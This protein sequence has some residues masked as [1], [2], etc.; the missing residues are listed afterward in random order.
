MSANVECSQIVLNEQ[1][2]TIWNKQSQEEEIQW[3]L[4]HDSAN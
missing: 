1:D 4:Q 2:V 3:S